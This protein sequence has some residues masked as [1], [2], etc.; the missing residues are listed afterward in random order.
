MVVRRGITTAVVALLASVGTTAAADPAA[1]PRAPAWS[2]VATA[3]PR[4]P[5]ARPTTALPAWTTPPAAPREALKGSAAGSLRRL[6]GSENRRMPTDRPMVALTFNAAWD[7]DGLASVLEQLR[8]RRVP[9][10]FFVTG[11]FAERHP[12]AAR[13]MA[14][15]QG[16]ASHSYSHPQLAD[17]TCEG[18]LRQVLKADQ[19]IRRAAGVVPLPFYRFP[20][21]DTSPQAIT[22]VNALGYADIEFTQDTNGY[23]GEGGGMT[24]DKAVQNAVDGLQ[25]G[26]ILELHIG[27]DAG[28]GPNL[29]HQALPRIID[30]IQARGYRIT[31]LRTLL[32]DPVEAGPGPTGR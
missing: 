8:E 31:D 21:S 19:A 18:L 10:T 11:Q 27:A 16:I 20:Y 14:S 4:S 13:A 25:P 12:A 1:V 28:T 9:A 22:E 24:V 17:L 2:T 29:D 3:M 30:A 7:E 26:A 6:F 15:E 32:R 23:L 5:G